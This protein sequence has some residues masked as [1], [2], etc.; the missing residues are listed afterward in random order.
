MISFYKNRG[1]YFLLSGLIMLIGVVFLVIN[2]IELDI[3]FQGGTLL[4][5]TFSGDMETQEL[6]RVVSDASDRN[7]SVQITQTPAGDKKAVINMAGNESI[8]TETLAAI[9][10]ALDNAYPDANFSQYEINNVEPYFGKKFFQNGI[11]AIILSSILIV[12]YVWIRFRKISGLSAGVMALVALFHDLLVAFFIHVIFGIPIGENFVAVALT[13]IAYSINDTIVIYDRIRENSK[14]F[15]KMPID[16]MVDKSINQSLTRSINTNLAV[17][18]SIFLVFLFAAADGITSITSFA[19][20][21]AIGSLS[22]CYSTICLA[23]PLWVMW[24]KRKSK[25][26]A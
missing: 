2:G 17:F 23:G 20:P 10:N 7:V 26:R 19:L 1:K 16:E 12:I 25:A 8:S 13:I 3:Q 24:K 21:M 18:V 14:L 6:E 22:G 11:T 9:E 5:Y 4:Q 15:P